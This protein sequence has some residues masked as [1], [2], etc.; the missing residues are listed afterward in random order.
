MILLVFLFTVPRI[1]LT[2]ASSEF[3]KSL[4]KAAGMAKH[5]DD[6]AFAARNRMWSLMHTFGKPMWWIT[7]APDDVGCIEVYRLATG[8]KG[9]LVAAEQGKRFR[10]VAEQPGAAAVHFERIVKVFIEDILGWSE[11]FRAPKRKGG[12][13]GIPKA[14][15]FCVEGQKRLSLHLHCLVWTYGTENLFER[16][17][18]LKECDSPG[19]EKL[20]QNF[21]ELLDDVI[22]CDL[23]IPTNLYPKDTKDTCLKAGCNGNLGLKNNSILKEL[24]KKDRH[25]SKDPLTLKCRECGSQFGVLDVMF[26]RLCKAWKDS[27]REVPEGYRENA[28][29]KNLRWDQLRD[30]PIDGDTTVYQL[31]LARLQ[32]QTN[33]HAPKHWDTCFCRGDHKTCRFNVPHDPSDKTELEFHEGDESDKN[34]R[35]TAVVI[36][37]KRKVSS[38]YLT[39]MSPALLKVFLCNNYVSF[40]NNMRLGYYFIKYQT[41]PDPSNKQS[42]HDAWNG[43]NNH[44]ERHGSPQDSDR[45]AYSIGVGR[46]IAAAHAHTGGQLVGGPIAGYCLLRHDPYQMSHLT[47]PIL[48]SQGAAFIKGQPVRCRIGLNGLPSATILDYVYR[49]DGQLP[50][51]PTRT[52]ETVSWWEFVSNYHLVRLRQKESCESNE[53]LLPLHPHCKMFKILPNKKLV[54]PVIFGP[55]LGDRSTLTDDSGE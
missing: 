53:K 2:Q 51:D 6:H 20:K 32:Q 29:S 37:H 28:Y 52:W 3:I 16:F 9:E 39:C 31:N 27:G 8:K 38:I 22:D 36:R 30:I 47:S 54:L 25:R 35:L 45:T 42:L 49:P 48:P 33:C 13:F 41:K 46:L 15:T 17:K 19:F 23:Q 44:F 1:S 40:V 26:N 55:T 10:L 7:F 11:R 34:H 5:T 12:I 21:T 43:F 4:K 24:R 50:D 18:H 14:W